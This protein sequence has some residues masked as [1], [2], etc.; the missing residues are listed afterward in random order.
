MAKDATWP[1]SSSIRPRRVTSYL[2]PTVPGRV[3]LP[4]YLPPSCIIYKQISS[5]LNLKFICMFWVGI[6]VKN[7]RFQ[8]DK[9]LDCNLLGYNMLH[10]LCY[11]FLPLKMETAVSSK[12]FVTT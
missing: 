8:R 4:S 2:L 7:F 12:T 9:N 3:S 5:M 10:S 6:T 11:P 1:D